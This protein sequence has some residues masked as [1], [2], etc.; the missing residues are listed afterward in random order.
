MERSSLPSFDSL[1]PEAR[2]RIDTLAG[3]F[4]LTHAQAMALMMLV[5]KG[6][7]DDRILAACGKSG[8]TLK[9]SDL[10]VVREEID[11]WI[12]VPTR[13]QKVMEILEQRGLLTDERRKALEEATTAAAIMAIYF[14]ATPLA[15]NPNQRTTVDSVEGW[16][17][18][19]DAL[20]VLRLIDFFGSSA[21]ANTFE[22]TWEFTS[23]LAGGA[24]DLISGAW[25]SIDLSSLFDG[26]DL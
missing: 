26:F 20:D 23:G 19:F 17:L 15:M 6:L 10:R 8:I 13:R 2:Q 7:P 1:P 22:K 25:E 3:R 9:R 12:T 18:F 11:Q 5:T 14:E 16:W 21:L 4:G 24:G